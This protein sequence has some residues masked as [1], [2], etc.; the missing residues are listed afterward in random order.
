MA[1]HCPNLENQ[2]FQHLMPD[3]C[4]STKRSVLLETNELT[5][6]KLFDVLNKI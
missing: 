2:G 3:A 4:I 6:Y 1:N 5:K